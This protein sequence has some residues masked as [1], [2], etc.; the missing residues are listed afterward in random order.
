M[1]L[2]HLISRPHLSGVVVT[3]DVPEGAQVL[4]C[5]V[6]GSEVDATSW[7]P[8][9]VLLGYLSNPDTSA[10]PPA[11]IIPAGGLRMLPDDAAIVSHVANP[12]AER[13]LKLNAAETCTMAATGATVLLSAGGLG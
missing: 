3:V 2:V 10:N 7:L 13:V 4:G 11:D 12:A 6:D 8:D 9:L 1:Q 5:F